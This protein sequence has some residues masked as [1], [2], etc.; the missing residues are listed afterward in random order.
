M[1][2]KAVCEETGL[3]DRAVRYYIDEGL[4]K[5]EFTENY[6]GRRSYD[7]TFEDISLLSDISTLRKFGFTVA[8]VK[9]IILDPRSSVSVIQKVRERKYHEIQNNAIAITALEN[10]DFTKPY[11]VPQLAAELENFTRFAPLPAED[12]RLSNRAVVRLVI[13]TLLCALAVIFFIIPLYLFVAKIVTFF[14]HEYLSFN[15]VHITVCAFLICTPVLLSLILKLFERKIKL[16]F[17]IR[18]MLYVI[19]YFCL[20]IGIVSFYYSDV[21]SCTTDMDNY[22]EFGKDHWAQRIKFDDFVLNVF[23]KEPFEADNDQTAV[24]YYKGVYEYYYILDESGMELYAEWKLDEE[25]F[26]KEVDRVK[27]YLENNS[28]SNYNYK[29]FKMR[30]LGDFLCLYSSSATMRWF[31]STDQLY[32]C[33]FFAYNPKTYTVRYYIGDNQNIFFGD[34]S[35]CVNLEW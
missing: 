16:R 14:S 7:F 34:D 10:M 32:S 27:S 24:Y 3:T 19:S 1:K 6:V 15:A 13:Y 25:K 20:I 8:E 9:D 17:G 2:I 23:P 18:L 30:N 33:R 26:S 12:D 35:L 29:T 5:P 4:I 21:S 11:T 31:E 22:L 28:S